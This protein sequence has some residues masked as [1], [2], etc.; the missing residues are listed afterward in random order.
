MANQKHTLE[1]WK[2]VNWKQPVQVIAE[3]MDCTEQTVRTWAEKVGVEVVLLRKKPGPKSRIDWDGVDWKKSTGEIA[4]LTGYSETWV[5]IQRG[6]NAARKLKK[7][8][9]K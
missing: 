1:D 5:E 3:R 9:K 8:S 4:A 6:R 7:A 2:K